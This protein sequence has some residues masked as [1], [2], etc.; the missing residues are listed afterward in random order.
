MAVAAAAVVA[1]AAQKQ[2]SSKRDSSDFFELFM[3]QYRKPGSL[4]VEGGK[5]KEKKKK[6]KKKVKRWITVHTRYSH[7]KDEIFQKKNPP[8]IKNK[9]KKNSLEKFIPDLTFLKLFSSVKKITQVHIQLTEEKH[10]QEF[11]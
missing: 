7:G 1:A 11:I 10:T 6:K 3:F 9:Y 4:V 8:R 5:K 2:R